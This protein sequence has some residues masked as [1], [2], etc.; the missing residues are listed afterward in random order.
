MPDMKTLTIDGVTFDVVDAKSVK[1]IDGVVPDETGNVRLEIINKSATEI[2]RMKREQPNLFSASVQT[3]NL[4]DNS[5][6]V[7][8]KYIASNGE[9]LDRTNSCATEEYVDISR[10]E[11]THLAAYKCNSDSFDAQQT[12]NR[13]CFYDANKERVNYFDNGNTNDLSLAVVEIPAGAVYV[14]V[15]YLTNTAASGYMVIR[16]SADME[17]PNYEPVKTVTVIPKNLN[18]KLAEIDSI[19]EQQ[20]YLFNNEHLTQNLLDNSKMLDGYRIASSG[21]L[22]ALA[23]AICSEEFIDITKKQGSHLAVYVYHSELGATNSY[24]RMAFYDQNKVMIKYCESTSQKDVT[25]AFEEIP[26]NAVYVRVSFLTK[27]ELYTYMVVRGSA[28]MPLDYYEYCKTVVVPKNLNEKLAEIDEIKQSIDIARHQDDAEFTV[29]KLNNSNQFSQNDITFVGDELWV[30]KE[31]SDYY[32]NGTMIFRY[33]VINGEFALVGT[34]DCDFGHLNTMD[35]CAAND[36]LIFG[37]GGNGTETEGNYFVVVKNPLSL[38]SMAL[39]ADVGIKYDVD[40]G[41]KVQALWGGSNLGDN[42]IVYLLSNNSANITK[43]LL[44]K[45]DNGEFNGEFVTLETHEL[46]V[47]GVQG[48]DIFGDTLYIGGQLNANE[49]A[50]VREISLSDFT[51]IRTVK[52]KFYTADGT[53]ITGCVQGIYVDAHSVWICV[54][55]GDATKPV[56]LTKYYR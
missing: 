32:T 5:L 13:M 36:C 1:S 8:G 40:I 53:A 24:Y 47:W 7:D 11:G 23:A 15:S 37:N 29:T 4:L 20:P 56:C 44:K 54:N 16:G 10:A 6:L 26:A 49:Y 30:S 3:G 12:Y 31:N 51:T 42:N 25:Y 22:G 18:D 45:G 55:S 33:K 17:L 50:A 39:I 27:G 19:S 38:G 9:V 34:C 48:A 28:D 52:R 35:Y 14:R 2:A 43:V 46:E 21:E 41:Y